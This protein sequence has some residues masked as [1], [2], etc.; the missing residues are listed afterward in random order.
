VNDLLAANGLRFV[1]L[2]VNDLHVNRVGLPEQEWRGRSTIL[3]PVTMDDGVRYHRFDRCYGRKDEGT[4]EQACLRDSSETCDA[5][6]LITERNL[7]QL[8]ANEG[9]S[10]LYTHWTHYRSMP[11]SDETIGRFRLLRQWQQ[12]GRVW[13]TS[14][15]QLLEWTR[16][17][18]FLDFACSSNRKQTLIEIKG[19]DD[20][21]FG[22]EAVSAHD[23]HGLSF[24]VQS[25]VEIRVV[26]K[27]SALKP[28]QVRR[29]GDRLWL[30]TRQEMDPAEMPA[31]SFATTA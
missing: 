6:V 26:V 28:E 17:R 16:R 27:G 23:L 25:Q 5:S 19:I 13:V 3:R 8:C 7:T 30:H 14:L 11:L 12:A 31:E 22:Y 9:T 18:T 24:R 2:N 20:P 21:L 1:W 15:R 29:A 10:I 4:G